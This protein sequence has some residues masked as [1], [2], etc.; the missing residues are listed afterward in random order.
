M[1]R[2][3]TRLL[4]HGLR[5]TAALVALLALATAAIYRWQPAWIEALD[6]ALEDRRFRGRELELAAAAALARTDPEQAALPLQRLADDHRGFGPGDRQEAIYAVA[7]QLLAHTYVVQGKPARAEELLAPL[8]AARPQDLPLRLQLTD[9]WQ[10]LPGTRARAETALAELFALLPEEQ[11]VAPRLVG[12]HASTSSWLQ[13]GL[14]LAGHLDA[15][16]P[17]IFEL[18]YETDPPGIAGLQRARLLVSLAPDGALLA[19]VRLPADVSRVRIEL[20]RRGWFQVR[21]P[22]LRLRGRPAPVR[23]DPPAPGADLTADGDAWRCLGGIAPQLW[24]SLA[25]PTSEPTEGELR[26]QLEALPQEPLRALLLAPS[27][28]QMLAALERAGHTGA[29]ATLRRHRSWFAFAAG[30]GL[31]WRSAGQ[32]FD[33]TRVRVAMPAFRVP[34]ADGIDFA[35]VLPLDAACDQLRLQLPPHPGIAFE[36]DR[37]VVAG[38]EGEIDLDPRGSALDAADLEPAPPAFRVRGPDPWLAL[39][40]PAQRRVGTVRVQG[41]LP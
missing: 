31:R 38:P 41:R 32:P 30:V 10:Q 34:R 13:A 27:G 1:P 16:R 4:V 29:A 7:T 19:R 9:L 11:A 12:L 24:L 28:E 17:W 36:L 2:N 3:A 15:V 35:V 14:T 18:A 33:D 21:A 39:V 6:Q 25:P 40:L 26:L 8:S 22:E 37:I 20:P 23:P 5:G